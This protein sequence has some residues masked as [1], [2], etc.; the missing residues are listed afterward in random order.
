MY[1]STVRPEYA[2]Q[3]ATFLIFLRANTVIR[4]RERIRDLSKECVI[5]VL[6]EQI[7]RGND[8]NGKKSRDHGIFNGTCTTVV[9]QQR[10]SR[11]RNMGMSGRSAGGMG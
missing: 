9:E 1:A 8:K 5:Y 11:S 7:D 4:S 3:G 2:A 10:Q 6:A